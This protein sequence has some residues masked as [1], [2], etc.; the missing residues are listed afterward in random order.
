MIPAING[1][2][3]RPTSGQRLTAQ[4]V[5][6]LIAGYQARGYLVQPKLNGD[7]AVLVATHSGLQLWN[8]HGGPYQAACVQLWQWNH[9]P[10]GTILDGEVYDLMFCPFEVLNGGTAI[11]RAAA[12]K[13][14]CQQRGIAYLFD[15]PSRGWLLDQAASTENILRRQWEGVVCKHASSTYRPLHAAHQES[16]EWIK[17]KWS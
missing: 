15:E 3:M 12:A 1:F 4:N 13:Q 9:L 7:R 10:I 5:H 8:R 16:A 14:L 17:L 2:P 6:Q 11:A